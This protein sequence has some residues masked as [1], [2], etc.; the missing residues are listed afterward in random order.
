MLTLPLALGGLWFVVATTAMG[1]TAS[2]WVP[3][4]RGA[5]A[6]RWSRRM[7]AVALLVLATVAFAG[8]TSRLDRPSLL[9]ASLVLGT[10][11]LL[12]GW[13]RGNRF[14]RRSEE[15]ESWA[16]VRVSPE[17]RIPWIAT[18]AVLALDLLVF[19]PAPPIDWDAMTYHLYLPA[20]WLQEGSWH[21]VPTVFGDNA[22]AFAPQNGALVFTWVLALTASDAAT[23]VVQG[24]ALVFLGLALYR[25]A[26]ALGVGVTA[27]GLAGLVVCWLQ[28]L[29]DLAYSANVD[30]WLLAAW[31]GSLAWI[32]RYRR[33]G[34]KASLTWGGA[35]A[36][37]AAGTKVV[38]LPLAGFLAIILLPALRARRRTLD[39]VFFL[40]PAVGLGGAWY[41][42][43]L[44]QFG[45]PLFPLHLDL[46]WWSWPGAY[47]TAAVRAGEFHLDTLPE[48]AASAFRGLGPGP[49][50]WASIGWLA[51]VVSKGRT[52][53]KMRPALWLLAFAW[54]AYF[55]MGIPHNNQA[56]FLL[57]SFLVAGL[58][59]GLAFERLRFR[60]WAVALG[61][62]GLAVA[63]AS[64]GVPMIEQWAAVLSALR[65][66]GVSPW[67]WLVPVGLCLGLAVWGSVRLRSARSWIAAAV[68]VVAMPLAALAAD[69]SRAA[70]FAR[71]DFRAWA[72]GVRPFS[73]PEAPGLRIAYTGA[74]FPY[75]LTGGGRR[76][77]V[78][79][80]NTQGN[81]GD[82]FYDHWSRSPRRYDY[83][84]PGIHRGEDN[85]ARWLENLRR[86]EIELLVIFR[87]H[88][89]EASYLWTDT[90]GFPIE[91]SWA[92]GRP[93]LFEPVAIHPV[94]EI[95]RWKGESAL[96]R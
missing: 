74:N 1:T 70:F 20:R 43:N 24:G 13:R 23:N 42:W 57:P 33:T 73:D 45:N 19:W 79:Y 87:L 69:Q 59:W 88:R 40:F 46:G 80:V 11:S 12:L 66:G 53:R 91:S 76:H 8:A 90:R 67:Q 94:V 93:D 9:A 28:P 10:G 54:G 82:G 15:A 44:W 3:Q 41:V 47:D 49:W 7:V 48:V 4:G 31:F 60:G 21:H 92:R 71:S 77:R 35:A 65:A 32:L 38:G 84:K 39:A 26:R 30:L 36:G 72:P 50:L 37:L 75:A 6:E 81:P 96:R 16:D 52:G 85:Q 25:G 34:E 29:R 17:P 95:Y 63:L 55:A 58:G 14:P 51:L 89:S 5:A 2:V 86:E 18:G 61:G 62:W 56:R 22:A 68:V 64:G 27:A 78:V 83:H